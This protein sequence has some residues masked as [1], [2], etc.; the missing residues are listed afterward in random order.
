M[1]HR[2]G[3]ES[4]YCAA[5]H[6]LLLTSSRKHVLS[7]GRQ[8]QVHNL[9]S[10]KDEVHPVQIFCSRGSISKDYWDR[11]VVQ[12][13]NFNCSCFEAIVVNSNFMMKNTFNYNF[14][15]TTLKSKFIS[16]DIGITIGEAMAGLEVS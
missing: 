11:V 13:F 1:N 3:A 14:C 12:S 15:S 5:C 9:S 4:L 8:R 6:V 2:A 7:S 16:I 10:L